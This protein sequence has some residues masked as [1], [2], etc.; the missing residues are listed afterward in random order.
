MLEAH[1]IARNIFETMLCIACIR[2]NL[3]LLQYCLTLNYN[4]SELI[5]KSPPTPNPIKNATTD[6]P[7]LEIWRLLI[8]NGLL[9]QQAG[10]MRQRLLNSLAIT[11]I[12]ADRPRVKLLQDLSRHGLAISNMLLNVAA[13]KTDPDTMRYLVSKCSLQDLERSNALLMAA[14]FNR[15]LIELLLDS[16]MNVNAEGAAPKDPFDFRASTTPLHNAADRGD[17]DAVK[18]LLARGA[19]WTKR[20]NQR[21]TAADRAE[22]NGH[23]EVADFIRKSEW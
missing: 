9:G 21:K 22:E 10:E 7:D 15:R 13:Q 3:A 17:M 2:K 12:N 14:A 1:G 5:S 8:E 16:G 23:Q 6:A 4:A 11:A 20:D 19:S 18:L